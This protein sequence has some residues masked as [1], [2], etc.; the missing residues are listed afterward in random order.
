MTEVVM[1]TS[2][3]QGRDINTKPDKSSR[4]GGLLKQF[5]LAV[6]LPAGFFLLGF[7][8][9]QM[10]VAKMQLVDRQF[11]V[12]NE[13]TVHNMA[14]IDFISQNLGFVVLYFGCFVAALF[15]LGMR[16][17]PRWSV[18]G[19]GI[20]FAL[21]CLVYLRVCGYITNKFIF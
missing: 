5:G 1:A 19:T 18:W 2:A 15:Y 12:M 13:K 14:L 16:K 8:T 17:C 3:I 4:L 11:L 9:H 6:A 21:P 20:I 7:L 10:A